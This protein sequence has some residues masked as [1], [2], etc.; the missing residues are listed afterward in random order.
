MRGVLHTVWKSYGPET[1]AR[2]L[3]SSHSRSL[4]NWSFLVGPLRL[5]LFI[6]GRKESLIDN[7]LIAIHC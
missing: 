5:C 3:I 4:E 2:K 1:G 6:F 7:K